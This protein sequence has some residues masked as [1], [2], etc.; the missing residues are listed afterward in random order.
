M[1]ISHQPLRANNLILRQDR[2][3]EGHCGPYPCEDSIVPALPCCRVGSAVIEHVWECFVPLATLSAAR[4]DW[5]GPLLL[6]LRGTKLRRALC[7]KRQSANLVNFPSEMKWELAGAIA[8]QSS[9]LPWEGA[10]SI[11]AV[12]MT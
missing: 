3:L 2:A 1:N 5:A 11:L 7:M 10:A 12:S 8:T 4:K 6:A 9:A